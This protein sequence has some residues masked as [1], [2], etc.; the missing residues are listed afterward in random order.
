MRTSCRSFI[1]QQEVLFSLSV[2]RDIVQS[3]SKSRCQ[4]PHRESAAPFIGRYGVISI[5]HNATASLSSFSILSAEKPVLRYNT[6]E[7]IPSL[8]LSHA[9]PGSNDTYQS[10]PPVKFSSQLHRQNKKHTAFLLKNHIPPITYSPA[11]PRELHSA[12]FA[13]TCQSINPIRP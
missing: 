5:R 10:P 7:Y 11:Q 13:A 3:A 8:T 12:C 2:F 1:L 6:R 4:F 9:L